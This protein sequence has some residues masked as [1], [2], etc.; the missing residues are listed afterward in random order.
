MIV[1]A[2]LRLK[3]TIKYPTTIIVGG[4]NKLGLE[5]ADSLIKQ[6]G[7][8]IIVDTVTQENIEK[9]NIFSDDA[10]IS[11]LDFTAIPHLEEDVRR[12][13]YVFYFAH[14]SV[15]FRNKVSTQEFL[16]FS[17]YLDA[18]LSLASKFEAR[19]LLTT[20][21][22]AHQILMSIK[23]VGVDF[24]YGS[25]ISHDAY[26]DLEVQRYAEGL[27]SEYFEKVNLSTRIIRLGEIIG[28]GIDFSNLTVFN[29]LVLNAVKGDPLILHKD[30]LESEWFVN[31]LDAAYALIKAQFSKNAEGKIFSVCYENTYTHLSLAYK[32]QEIEEFAKDIQFLDEK[33]N[34]PPLKLYKPAP[35]L[36]TIG[37]MPR[38]QFDK[39]V[40]QSI[41]AAKI[42][43]VEKGLKSVGDI[44]PKQINKQKGL[45]SKFRGFINLA[46]KPEEIQI[47]E[48][49]VSKLIEQKK[50]GDELTKQR[51]QQATNTIRIKKKA[52]QLSTKE[53]FQNTIWGITK[54][55]GNNFSFLS[56]KSPTELGI[57]F[58]LLAIFLIIYFWILSPLLLITRNVIIAMPRYSDLKDS[59]D[60]TN[61]EN[62]SEKSADLLNAIEDT[63]STL[64]RLERI[65]R[66]TGNE[67]EYY[68]LDSILSNYEDYLSGVED[69]SDALKSYS[70]YLTLFENNTQVRASTDGYLTIAQDDLDYS[71]Y[72]KD[73]ELKTP[74][75]ERGIEKINESYIKII[76]TLTNLLP[77]FLEK[78]INKINSDINLYHNEL[79]SLEALK[80][81]P[82]VLG[83]NS[84]KTY[85]ILLLDNSKPRPVGGDISAFAM[86]TFVNGGIADI[87]VQSIEDVNISSSSFDSEMINLINSRRF[88]LKNQSNLKLT[89]I[90]SISDFDIF[91]NV[92]DQLF[93][94]NLNREINGVI[95]LNLN[96]IDR[97]L[98]THNLGNKIQI[99]GV[100]FENIDFL[101]AIKISQV[102]PSSITRKDTEAQILGNYLFE[103]INIWKNDSVGFIDYINNLA[104]SQEILISSPALDFREFINTNDLGQTQIRETD[105]YLSIGIN[106]AN[107][108]FASD[109]FLNAIAQV[110][111]TIDSNFNINNEL[112]LTFPNI[113]VS[114]EISVCLPLNAITNSIAIDPT[115]LPSDRVTVNFLEDD[116]CVVMQVASESQIKL[117][118]NVDTSIASNAENINLSLGVTK[119]KGISTQLDYQISLDSSLRVESINLPIDSITNSIIFSD[120]LNKD[121][122]I[123]LEI[124]KGGI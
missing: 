28:D 10:M 102:S 123:E 9:F 105:S 76:N 39:A 115:T 7:Y 29:K 56:K 41:A 75:L 31:V 32:I 53:K 4:L 67:S 58:A 95:A 116:K 109:R 78:R 6:G 118:W 112:T 1:P 68:T 89:D 50:A 23:Q 11:F 85:L 82:E 49:P 77:G 90:S 48:N 81:L 86:I 2:N 42:Y 83:A 27:T 65:A 107:E 40:A 25:E 61:I 122:V 21:I 110:K 114:Q 101:N 66:I 119:I 91:A 35:N 72:L 113:G 121:M 103:L 43:I 33:D 97:L 93:E 5:I 30:G 88:I 106:S 36:S 57:I 80:Y 54:K 18:T 47:E 20:A 8:A 100:T 84:P 104:N 98:T 73:I 51:L 69:I 24:G 55:I 3:N 34:L 38:V 52:R 22:K 92:A 26:T 16:T 94:N 37:W 44:E 111:T 64:D 87:K 45:I 108:D 46:E 62:L 63:R 60:V 71:Q 17:N 117:S 15:D 59:I 74:N 79:Q 120:K 124:G 99:N 70:E 19:F 12:L 14:T 13:D 96:S